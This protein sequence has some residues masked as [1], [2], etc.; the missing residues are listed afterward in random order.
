MIMR[1]ETDSVTIEAGRP[2]WVVVELRIDE[3]DVFAECDPATL[4]E[5]FSVEFIKK[6]LNLRD[7]E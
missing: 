2:G 7:D 6:Q 1:F 4:L 3:G 5:Q